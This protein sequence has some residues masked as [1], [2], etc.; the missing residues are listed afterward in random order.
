MAHKE[1]GSGLDADDPPTNDPGIPEQRPEISFDQSETNWRAFVRI[2]SG[3]TLSGV[4]TTATYYGLAIWTYQTTG[5][6]SS[7]SLVLLASLLPQIAVL[8]LAGALI[9]RLDRRRLMMGADSVAALAT[10]VLIGLFASGRL[11]TLNMAVVVAVG[12]TFQG[13]QSPAFSSVTT[14]L[15][16]RRDRNRAGGLAQVG[17]AVPTV[18]GPIVAG[19]LLAAVDIGWVFVLDLV[20][21]GAAL[22]TLLLTSVPRAEKTVAGQAGAGTIRHEVATAARYLLD[23]RGLAYLIAL[24]AAANIL[25][26]FFNIYLFPVLLS[27]GDE[28][29]VGLIAGL[30]A[31]GMTAGAILMSVWTGPSRRMP[32]IFGASGAIAVA[33]MVFGVAHHRIVL[34]AALLVAYFALAVASSSTQPI[35]QNKVEVDLQGRVFAL[36]R[37]VGLSTMPIVYIAA[38]PLADRILAPRV[39]EDA[40]GWL[41]S[42]VGT[43]DGRAAAAGIFLVGALTLIV[44][45]AFMLVKPLRNVESDLPDLS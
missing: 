29:T 9:D 40:K 7:L 18:V 19:A 45:A 42:V 6:T 32:L 17:Q 12:S 30:G 25:L 1:T 15:V 38:G 5:S 10:V 2:W 31:L 16:A 33:S 43:G 13:I 35:F 34:G 4:G 39:V 41:A 3:Q 21:F 14:S 26:A 11:T 20:S 27:V 22:L 23:K 37:M 36:R 44:V 28:R 8:P 24:I